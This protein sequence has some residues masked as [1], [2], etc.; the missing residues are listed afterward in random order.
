MGINFRTWLL[1]SLLAASAAHAGST[2]GKNYTNFGEDLVAPIFPV[3]GTLD[4]YQNKTDAKPRKTIKRPVLQVRSDW[5]SCV[6]DAPDGWVYCDL[7]SNSGWIKRNAFRSGGEMAPATP[8]PF[9]YWMYV[10]SDGTGGEEIST[11]LKAARQS[12]YL[13]TPREY[14]NVFFQ[15]RFDVDGRAISPKTG[16]LTGDRVFVV[17]T[18]VYLAPDDPQKRSGATWLFL[19]HYHHALQALCPSVN[20]DS[21]Q[22]AVNLSPDWQGI[23]EFSAEPPEPFRKKDDDPSRWS[24]AGFVAFARHSDAVV[25]FMYRVPSSV[26]MRADSNPLSDAER[27]RNRRTL[28]CIA[29]CVKQ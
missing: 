17:G 18:A 3:N 7:A 6:K 28:F 14:D 29:D 21:C 20:P 5:K 25:P 19:N 13:V 4:I 16:K 1:L 8:W 15:V 22:S 23:R 2:D 12:P 27:D 11:L 10:A 24:G 26:H 9:R